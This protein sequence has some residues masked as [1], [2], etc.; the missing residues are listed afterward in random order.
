M[1]VVAVG[2]L[3]SIIGLV[4]ALLETLLLYKAIKNTRRARLLARVPWSKI[5][6]LQPGLVKVQGQAL[7]VRGTLRGPLSGR[8]CV[9]YKFQV[10]EKRRY[11]ASPFTRGTYWKSAINDA[12]DMPCALHDGTGSATVRLNSAELV[13]Q[14]DANERSGFLNSARPELEETLH[15]RYGYSSV[16]LMFNRTLDYSETRIEEGDVLVV[17]G[18]ARE[19][20]GGGWELV[21][22]DI[23][24]LVS[25][26][27]LAGL[28]ASYRSAAF[29]WWCLAVLLPI[30]ASVAVIGFWGL[31]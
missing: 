25:D 10:Q 17:L 31:R 15:A 26:K 11:G 8:E 24:L 7:A 6:Q 3:C 28:L 21:R 18:T 1:G 12:Q 13:L 23:P 29:L 2:P 20:P 14:P 9:Y 16:G 4:V 30:I 19:V 22:G 27:G 5:G